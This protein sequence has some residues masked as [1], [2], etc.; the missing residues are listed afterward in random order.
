MDSKGV[1]MIV[2][3]ERLK[4]CPIRSCQGAAYYEEEEVLH[5][6]IT[7]RIRCEKCGLTGYKT[8]LR[9][10]ERDR[11]FIKDIIDYWNDR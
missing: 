4:R 10:A 9:V 6:M 7:I 2:F 3:D 1:N 5:N 11:D 8:H